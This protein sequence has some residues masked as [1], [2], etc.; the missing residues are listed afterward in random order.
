MKR[1]GSLVVKHLITP[2]PH[3][4]DEL[5]SSNTIVSDEDFLYHSLALIAVYKL[6]RSRH[7]QR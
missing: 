2:S 1:D 7:L 6:S 4:A 5:H 3:R